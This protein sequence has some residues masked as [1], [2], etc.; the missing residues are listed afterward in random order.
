MREIKIKIL[1]TE[2]GIIYY[3]NRGV[4]SLLSK[5]LKLIFHLVSLWQ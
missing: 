4:I 5:S 2:K 1:D 3:D